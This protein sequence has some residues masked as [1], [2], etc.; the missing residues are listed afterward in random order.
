MATI[1]K[2]K[3]GRQA[4]KELTNELVVHRAKTRKPQCEDGKCVKL[5]SLDKKCILCDNVMP[6]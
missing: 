1:K 6:L 2:A 3:S 4:M 5:W